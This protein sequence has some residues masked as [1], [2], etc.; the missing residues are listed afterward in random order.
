VEEKITELEDKMEIK[1]ETKELVVL[2]KEY[3]RTHWLSKEQTWES[4]ALKK[5]KRNKQKYL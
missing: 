1:G 2:W 4:W 5:E 3:A